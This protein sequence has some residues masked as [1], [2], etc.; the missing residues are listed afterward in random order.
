MKLE[1]LGYLETNTDENNLWV[2]VQK[3]YNDLKPTEDNTFELSLISLINEQKVRFTQD[4]RGIVKL[5]IN[6]KIENAINEI[7]KSALEEMEEELQKC[8][9]NEDYEGAVEWRDMINET[10]ENVK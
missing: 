2:E 9:D 5:A 10:K 7:K 3:L 6:E 8:V 1:I 4:A